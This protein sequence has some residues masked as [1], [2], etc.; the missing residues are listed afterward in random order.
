MP[1]AI[2]ALRPEGL[3]S[4]E[5]FNFKGTAPSAAPSPFFV[6]VLPEWRK[7]GAGVPKKPQVP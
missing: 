7:S 3:C 5:F 1:A 6:A 2:A 4:A